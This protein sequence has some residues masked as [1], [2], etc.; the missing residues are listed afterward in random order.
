MPLPPSPAVVTDVIEEQT[1]RISEGVNRLWT[2][3]HIMDYV[4]QTRVELSSV[5]GVQI[6]ILLIEAIALHRATVPWRFVLEIPSLFGFPSFP[7]FVPDLF[8]FLTH[9][10]WAPSFLWITLNFWLPLATGWFFNLSLRLKKKDGLEAW[11]PKYRIDP[12]MFSIAKAL[13]SWMVYSQG[14]RLFGAFAEDTVRTVENA[15]PYGYAGVMVAAYVGIATSVW[16]GLQGKK[17]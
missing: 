13:L 3:S 6:S 10:Y 16:D 4:Y 17:G 14:N 2:A 11:R 9:Y 1:A 15:M 12:L 5:T 8:V 7:I